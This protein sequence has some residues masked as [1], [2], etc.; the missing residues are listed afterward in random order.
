MAEAKAIYLA[1]FTGID[2][3][4]DTQLRRKLREVAA[5]YQV[6]KNR[7]AKLAAQA[8]GIPALQDQ[9]R[10]PTAIAFAKDD[11]VAPAK[12]IDEFIA[13]GG[14]LTVKTGYMDGNL[15]SVEQVQTLAR[16]PSR[17]ELLGKV[18]GAT[19]A[20]LQGLAAVL[21]GLLR[22]V[23]VAVSAIEEKRRTEGTGGAETAADPGV[24]PQ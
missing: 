9:L 11:P 24:A 1:D 10:G 4:S 6:V 20:P 13:A 18:V 14:K 17:D 19:Q 15:L 3:A 23:V 12:V 7:L 5:D 8:A 22:G 2:V 16:L 21:T